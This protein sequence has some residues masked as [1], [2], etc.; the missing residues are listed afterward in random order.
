MWVLV[1]DTWVV[2]RSIWCRAALAGGGGGRCI[3]SRGYGGGVV[4]EGVVVMRM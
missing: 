2:G 1:V 3:N 4:G